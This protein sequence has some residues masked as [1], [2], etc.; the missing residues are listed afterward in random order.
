MQCMLHDRGFVN[1]SGLIVQ[2]FPFTLKTQLFQNIPKR[3]AANFGDETF[4]ETVMAK[5]CAV[6]RVMIFATIGRS[7]A[8]LSHLTIMHSAELTILHVG[9]LRP[10]RPHVGL[11]C[12]LS[13]RGS[14]LVQGSS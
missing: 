13:R 5:V 9:L 10:S 1:L 11:Q 4:A 3:H 2:F 7:T 14:H 6:M 12:A 8:S